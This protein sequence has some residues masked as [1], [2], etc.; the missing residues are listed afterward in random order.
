MGTRALMG[1]DS[2]CSGNLVGQKKHRHLRSGGVARVWIKPMRSSSVSA[3]PKIPP[4]HTPYVRRRKNHQA[5]QYTVYVASMPLQGLYILEPIGGGQANDL[6]SIRESDA[7]LPHIGQRLQT[8]RIGAGRHDVRVVPHSL[9][10][11][12]RK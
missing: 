8:I 1:T 12:K 3:M 2:G 10:D 11:L 5:H 4:Q 9:R 6:D 7:C